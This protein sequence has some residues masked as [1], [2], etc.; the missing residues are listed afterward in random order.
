V[1]DDGRGLRFGSVAQQYDRFRPSPPREFAGL[2]GDLTGLD[3]LE[4]GAGTG[5]WTRFLVELGGSVT[6][7]EPDGEMRAVLERRSP[8]VRSLAGSAESLPVRDASFDVVVVSS[9][10]HWFDQPA[11]T[12]E[13]A[14]VLRDN[15]QLFVLWNGFSR[16]VPWLNRLTELR[17]NPRDP[18]ARPRGWSAVF[19]DEGLFLDPLD[20][21][22]D[23]TWTRTVEQLFAVFATYSGAIV[24]SDEDRLA[25]EVELR[26][27][28]NELAV[29]GVLEVPMTL[30]GT[31]AT[32]SAR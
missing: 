28:I 16:K 3:V 1:D 8:H 6:A 4:V 13:M 10:W 7:V 17:E 15:A 14:R 29:N 30:R 20:V 24:K 11:A 27:R 22:V 19:A 9:A 5:L 18:K 26:R 31:I 32:R 21:E 23:W 2:L 25:M 12:S